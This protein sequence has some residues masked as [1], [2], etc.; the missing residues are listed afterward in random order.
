MGRL[1]GKVALVTG[2]AS[3][4][5]AATVLRFANEGARVAGLDLHELDA[6][7]FHVAQEHKPAID[8]HRLVQAVVHRL[9]HERMVGNH[10]VTVMV[11]QAADGFGKGGSEH[12]LAPELTGGTVEVIQ[13]AQTIFDAI[14]AG[15][16]DDLCTEILE[17]CNSSVDEV[18]DPRI[19]R[20]SITN[21]AYWPALQCVPRERL[22]S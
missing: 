21:H 17:H 16:A 6:A 14:R 19:A 22:L 11:F 7:R 5:G 4:L 9:P 8:I 13:A 10:D 15:A 1:D 2:A 3:G 18:P 20:E 12:V